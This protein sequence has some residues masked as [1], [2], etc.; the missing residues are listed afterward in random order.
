MKESIGKFLF[1]P[2]HQSGGDHPIAQRKQ[3]EAALH[4]DWMDVQVRFFN[5][6]PALLY[7]TLSK[8]SIEKKKGILIVPYR[9]DE[10]CMHCCTFRP[11]SMASN[12]IF[13]RPRKKARLVSGYW[14]ALDAAPLLV[15]KFGLLHPGKTLLKV[16]KILRHRIIPPL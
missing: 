2:Y 9:S 4:E 7:P 16:Q 6:P 3:A 13:I 10:Q 1:F 5:P 15:D 14:S 8:M 11:K 12:W